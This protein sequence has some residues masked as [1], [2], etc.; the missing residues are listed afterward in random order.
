MNRALFLATIR[1]LFAQPVRTGALLG[2]TLLPLLQLLVDPNPRLGDAKWAVFIAVIAS[3]GVIGLEVSTGSLALFFT[4][5][6]TRASYVLSRWAGVATVSAS[7]ALISLG[8]E[9]ALILG[10][11]AEIE[12]VPLLIALIDRLAIAIGIVTTMTCFSAL[13][14]SLGDLVIWLSVHIL[15]ASLLASGEAAAMPVL[16]DIGRAVRR[17]VNPELDAFLLLSS[18]R[19]PWSQ[20]LFYA[21]TIV[22]GLAIAIFALNRKE[23]TY[24]SE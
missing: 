5:P 13:V 18:M 22:L 7:L 15:A 9:I 21:A 16:T 8:G 1:Q 20:V 6:I 2:C 11:D 17:A 24:A 3:A 19:V 14:S 10:R 23:L 4:R 12:A